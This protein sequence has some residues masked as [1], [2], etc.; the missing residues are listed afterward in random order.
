MGRLPIDIGDHVP[1]P[2]IQ[3]LIRHCIVWNWTNPRSRCAS[4]Q[5]VRFKVWLI[6][7]GGEIE[8]DGSCP[9]RRGPKVER[10]AARLSRAHVREKGHLPFRKEE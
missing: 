10:T 9:A 7:P 2:D 1:I 8:F 5:V 3:T 4:V 6:G